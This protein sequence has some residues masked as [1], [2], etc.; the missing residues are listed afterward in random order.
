METAYLSLGSNIGDRLNN[1]KNALKELEEAGVKIT[2]AS[3][4]YE[5]ESWGGIKQPDFLNACVKAETGFKPM[6]LLET[7]K[8]IEAKLGR[9]QDGQRWG[10]TIIDI[11]NIFYG[12]IKFE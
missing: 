7:I 10:P 8:G 3:S 1:L 5:S 12:K 4:V 9:K 2:A 6:G 11:D